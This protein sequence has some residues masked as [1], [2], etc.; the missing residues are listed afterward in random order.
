VLKAKE[1]VGV[2]FEK[3]VRRKPL[4]QKRFVEVVG[5]S[6]SVAEEPTRMG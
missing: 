4:E 1:G 6:R 2:A 3:A 5:W